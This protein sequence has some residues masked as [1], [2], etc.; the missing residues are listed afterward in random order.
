MILLFGT[1][2]TVETLAIVSFVCHYCGVAAP[3][4]VYRR[5]NRFT[6]F[7]LPLF[8]LSTRHFVE[9]SNCAATT[10]LT[11]EQARNGAAYAAQRRTTA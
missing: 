1:R 8:R 10:A 5:V 7:F 9:C 2:A 6:I 3:Q 4:E 11:E